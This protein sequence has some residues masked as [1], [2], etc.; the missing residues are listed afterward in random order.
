MGDTLMFLACQGLAIA[1]LA[2]LGG[3]LWMLW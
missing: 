2:I 1:A 3:V